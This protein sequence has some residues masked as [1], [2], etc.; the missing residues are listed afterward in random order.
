V[1][2]DDNRQRWW[3]AVGAAAAAVAAMLAILFWPSPPDDL[4]GIRHR[5]LETIRTDLSARGLRLGDPIFIRI[6]KET[7]ELELWIKAGERFALHKT[8]PIC[9]WSGDLG[10]KLREGDGQSPEGFYSVARDQMNPNSQYHLSFNLG[11]PNAFDRAQGR[12][13]SFVMVHGNCVSIGCYAMTDAGIE[14][15]WLIADEALKAGQTQFDVHAFPFR[16]SP[17]ALAAHQASPW[18]GFWQTLKVGY[19][20]FEAAH[21]PPAIT[22]V[23]GAYVVGS[24]TP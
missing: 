3:I 6:F 12:T 18:F 2:G 21:V 16:P 19:D 1:P 10:P 9:T 17:E 4:A 8:F 23:N 24:L 14:E 5:R 7:D 22:V 15:I 13:G 11:F 20:N